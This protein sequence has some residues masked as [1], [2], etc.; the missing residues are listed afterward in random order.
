MRREVVQ[1]VVVHLPLSSASVH[2]RHQRD[3][4]SLGGRHIPVE[5]GVVPGLVQHVHGR[6]LS[7]GL[8][9]HGITV[10]ERR[11]GINGEGRHA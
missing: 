8:V 7:F 5:D 1:V 6:E 4:L 2:E 10:G 3:F 9:F 11:F